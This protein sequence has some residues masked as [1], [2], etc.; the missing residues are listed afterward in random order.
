MNYRT[1]FPARQFAA[2]QFG[3]SPLRSEIVRFR[4]WGVLPVSSGRSFKV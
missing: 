3:F 1:G 2:F 4:P